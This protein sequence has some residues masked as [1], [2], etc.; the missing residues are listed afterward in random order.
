VKVENEK[1]W[2]NGTGQDVLRITQN[3]ET[4]THEKRPN[5]C[6]SLG[7]LLMRLNELTARKHQQKTLQESPEEQAAH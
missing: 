3:A 2:G 5:A 1:K 7:A 4:A 6:K